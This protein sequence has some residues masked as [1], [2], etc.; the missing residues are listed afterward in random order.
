MAAPGVEASVLLASH[1]RQR[2]LRRCLDALSRQSLD[3]AAFEVIV[4]DDGSAD[5]TAAMVEAFEAPYRLRLLRLQQGGQAAAQNAALAVAEGAM[6]LFLDDDIIASPQLLE[7]HLAAHRADPA[8]VGIGAIEQKPPAARDWYAQMFA[9]SWNAHYDEFQWRAAHWT[10][11]YG[12]NLSAPRASL[13]AIDGVATAV[14]VAFDLELGYRLERAGCRLAYLGEA[15]GVH[16]DDKRGRQ[17][18][19]DAV[20][21]GRVHAEL[22]RSHP[23]ASSDLLDWEERSGAKERA[24]RR[25][26]LALRL[27]PTLPARLGP[28][29][30]GIERQLLAY[31]IIRRLA[32]WSGVRAA[33]SRAEWASLSGSGRAS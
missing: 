23:E 24:L 20:R 26:L 22:A 31:A 29:L 28:L 1:N 2:L 25:L 7:A 6:C 3:P 33:V 21:Q 19:G 18:I 11:C 8:V 13:V 9:R 5:G 10:D 32:F 27:P 4:A 15:R 14:P 30:P 16:D 12:A 17:M